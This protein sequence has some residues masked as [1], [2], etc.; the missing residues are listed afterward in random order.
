MDIFRDRV[1]LVATR[2][3]KERVLAPILEPGLGVVCEIVPGLDTDR[4]GTF[5][6]EVERALSPLEAAREKCRMAMDLTGVD[7]ALASEGSF[8][9]HPAIPFVPADEE[10]LLLLDRRH[11]LEVAARVCSPHTNYSGARVASEAEL[12]AFAATAAFPSHALILRPSP[13]HAEAVIKG[14]TRW[15]ELAQGFRSLTEAYGTVHVETDMRAMYNPTRMQVIAEAGRKLLQLCL[16]ACPACGRPGFAVREVRTG[17]PCADCGTPTRGRLAGILGCEG[18]GH[19]QEEL[20]PDGIA[21]ED[22]GRCDV[23]NP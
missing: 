4:L 21:Q 14:I 10:V 23:C 15:E 8:G 18:C 17:L 19:R 7:L 3:G 9:P 12:E 16:S 6:G 13:A 20:Y 5:T 1:L 22:P 11:G 2:H